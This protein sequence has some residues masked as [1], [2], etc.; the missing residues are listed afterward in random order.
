MLVIQTAGAWNQI[1][2]V[3]ANW[4]SRVRSWGSGDA[5]WGVFQDAV[6]PVS[7][8]EGARGGGLLVHVDTSGWYYVVGDTGVLGSMMG[9]SWRY[10]ELVRHTPEEE[11]VI[12]LYLTEYRV[13]RYW[14]YAV[15]IRPATYLV[16]AHDA[17]RM[18][19][20]YQEPAGGTLPAGWWQPA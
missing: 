4:S 19:V 9:E 20:V 12:H 15:H 16:S 10:G 14:A 13:I 8:V 17:A 18:W 11:P 1:A 7:H 6:W 5:W 2:D 3:Y